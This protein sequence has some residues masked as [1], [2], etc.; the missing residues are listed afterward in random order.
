[1]SDSYAVH[2]G[3]GAYLDASGNLVFGAPD[4]AQIYEAPGGF[5]VDTQKLQDAFKSLS[6]LLPNDDK[7]KKQ[8]TDWGVPK[9]MVEFLGKLSSV[10]GIAATALAVYTWAIG[11]LI[12][13]M[14][15][16][17]AP[18]GMSPDLAN[19]LQNIKNQ[20]QGQEQIDRATHMIQ[21]HA[22]F[23]GSLDKM[24]GR[25]TEL[26][27]SALVGPA[28]AQIFAQ[29]QGYL[30][31][32][33]VPL[34][35]LRDQEWATTYNP[36]AY[37]G[38][39]FAAELLVYKLSDGSTQPVPIAAPNLT[40]FDYRLGVP[41]LLYAGAA[42]TA[43]V[44]VAMP[45]FRTAGIYAGEL[46][47][48]AE[49]IDRFVLRMQDE[50]LSLTEYTAQMVAEQQQWSIFEVPS[51]GGPKNYNPTPT[52][53]VGAFDLVT[54][55]DTYLSNRFVDDVQAGTSTGVRGLFDYHWYTPETELTRIANAA[56]DQ[57]KQA[58]AN[59]QTSSGMLRLIS[60]AAW[61]RYMTTPTMQSQTVTG[62]AED[63]RTLVDQE[64]TTAKSPNIFP[65]GVIEHDAT[66]R[67]YDARNRIQMA[68]QEPGY[69]PAYHYRV[70][71]RA[72]SSV[73]GNEGWS[74]REYVGDIWTADYEPTA[75]DPRCKRMTTIFR[76]DRVL[77]EIVLYEGSS[78]D[79]PLD[80]PRTHASVQATTFDWYVPVV[81]IQSRIHNPES[82]PSGI[83]GKFGGGADSGG[84]KNDSAGLNFGGVSIHLMGPNALEP[85]PQ[86]VMSQTYPM[87]IARISEV[88]DL[89]GATSLFD[90]SMDQ[91]ERRHVK[92]EKVEFDWQLSWSASELEVRLYG[93]PD[94][95]AF[96]LHLVVEE[97]V[98]SGETIPDSVKDV[99][100]DAQLRE[101]IHTAVVAEMV[102]QL[103]MVPQEFFDEERKAIDAGSKMWHA[104][105]RSYSKSAPVGPGDP[106]QRVQRTV[107]EM[108]A[109]S[110][111]TSTLAAA[112]DRRVEFARQHAPALWNAAQNEEFQAGSAQ[113]G[114]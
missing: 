102:N 30:D 93:Q 52:Y 106:I 12:S 89:P 103:V 23:D 40:T 85:A 65:V 39:G 72:L 105:Q 55:D 18:N 28:R 99:Y 51:G 111:S 100:A 101:V 31:E 88:F 26:I 45:W 49:A 77:S 112:M 10:V 4:K 95:R 17:A 21:M 107:R 54:Y 20:L 83:T 113:N 59:L 69:V 46:R 84:G 60:T 94:S 22:D 92:V 64:P 90:V 25:L 27:V 41:M 7:G 58:Y 35:N 86:Q 76:A 87:G 108:V 104:F 33:A 110:P 61:L 38:R 114:D 74:K 9:G 63:S 56:N 82:A 80:I 5:R 11:V 14:D 79:Q 66:L 57:A 19:A 71:L 47:R 36:D 43:M 53:A 37:K 29:M 48:T 98:Y 91:A 44:Q 32:L 97:T 15:L 1:M 16:M 24:K 2:I 70:V 42:Y 75:G 81:P 6:G 3:G 62:F 73:F 109:A 68:T 13:I 96:Q 67:R 34:S 78:P 50:C 8:W